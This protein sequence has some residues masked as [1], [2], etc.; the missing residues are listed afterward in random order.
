MSLKYIQKIYCRYSERYIDQ[1][2]FEALCEQISNLTNTY[3]GRPRFGPEVSDECRLLMQQ[4]RR[5]IGSNVDVIGGANPNETSLIFDTPKATNDNIL[6][7]DDDL[8]ENI[9]SDLV[10]SG[11]KTSESALGDKQSFYHNG[12]YNLNIL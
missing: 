4:H 11:Y 5:K 3:K 1:K 6:S 10:K 2:K 7:Q 12:G 8:I 9:D